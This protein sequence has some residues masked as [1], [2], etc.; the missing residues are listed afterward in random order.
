MLLEVVPRGTAESPM[1]S[2]G[3]DSGNQQN[4]HKRKLRDKALSAEAQ[5]LPIPVYSLFN[6][7]VLHLNERTTVGRELT[8]VLLVGDRHR[9]SFVKCRCQ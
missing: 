2:L 5:D 9:G 1:E 7:D 8:T 3:S 6:F 4:I